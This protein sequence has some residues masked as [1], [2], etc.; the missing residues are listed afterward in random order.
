[1]RVMPEWAGIRKFR[2]AFSLVLCDNAYVTVS[3]DAH[4]YP[5]CD[6]LNISKCLHKD[7]QRL[8][9]TKSKLFEERIIILERAVEIY[10]KR[11]ML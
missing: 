10:Y 8:H 11:F 6:Q 7:E 4:A 5:K 3:K 2:I 1:M 9:N